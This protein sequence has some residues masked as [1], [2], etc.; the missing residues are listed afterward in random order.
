MAEIRGD[1]V[2]AAWGQQIRS[3]VLHPY[4]LV[5]C[6]RTGHETSDT[7]GVLGGELLDGFMEAFLRHKGQREA[8]AALAEGGELAVEA[9]GSR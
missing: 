2:V 3:Y 8:A 4:S 5:K 6:T 7:D 9:A 1:M